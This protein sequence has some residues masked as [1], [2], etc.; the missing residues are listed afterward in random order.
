MRRGLKRIGS[1]ERHRFR[2]TFVRFG[3]KNGYMGEEDTIL[4]SDIRRTDN[5]A[6]ICDHLWFNVTKGFQLCVP[7]EGDILEFDARV[8]MYTKGYFGHREDV[9]VPIEKDYKLSRPTKI[10]NITNP[11][12]RAEGEKILAEKEEKRREYYRKKEEEK[13]AP[14]EITER[15]KNFIKIIAD[16]LEIEC[17]ENLTKEEASEWIETHVEEY[18]KVSKEKKKRKEVRA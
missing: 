16:V 15:Q 3:K 1:D 14:K 2:G 11:M 18:R 12:A 7:K 17:P 8:A 6:S 13:Y 10:V 9:Y 5:G 4:L